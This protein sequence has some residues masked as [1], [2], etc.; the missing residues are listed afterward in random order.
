M[1]RK[2][3]RKIISL[4]IILGV[5]LVPLSFL[6]SAK[7]AKAQLDITN[8]GISG[9]SSNSGGSSL[10]AYIS[11]LGPAITQLPLCKK[12][13]KSGLSD[14]FGSN[15]PEYDD[16]GGYTD[17]S[18][19]IYYDSQG[20]YYGD[21]GVYYSQA[22]QDEETNLDDTST[23]ASAVSESVPVKDGD[24]IK[25]QKDLNKK[26]ADIKSTSASIEKNDTCLKSIGRLIIKMLLQKITMATVN[27]INSGFN[28]GPAFV[29]NP[30]KFFGDIATNEILQFKIEIGDPSKFPF[31][32]A[33]MQGVAKNFSK[34]FADNAQYSLDTMIKATNPK[35]SAIGFSTD[36]TKGGW[37]AWKAMT[38][39]PGNNPMG[40]K[41]EASNE[42]NNRLAGLNKTIA[43]KT[44]EALQ[45]ANGFL[46][47]YRCA[48][49]KG[50]SKEDND[51]GVKERTTDPTG[52]GTYQYDVCKKWEYV[53]PGKIISEKATTAINYPDNQLLKA[54]D[55]NDSLAAIIDALVNHF[56]QKIIDEGL[57]GLNAFSEAG[58]NFQMDYANIDNGS[59]VKTGSTFNSSQIGSSAFLQQNPNFD[60]TKDIT[61]ALIDT[62]R[63]YIDKLKAQNDG[64]MRASSSSINGYD[65]LIPAIYQL[66]YCIP[67]P[68]PDWE[69]KAKNSLAKFEK[70]ALANANKAKTHDDYIAMIGQMAAGPFGGIVGL[71]QDGIDK[72]GSPGLSAQA[73]ELNS[74]YNTLTGANLQINADPKAC[75]TPE[76]FISNINS[77]LSKY[78]GLVKKNFEDL[79]RT[80]S[81]TNE[82]RTQFSKINGY[83]QMIEDNKVKI[84]YI[85]S[86]VTQLENI[87]S[88]VAE[89]ESGFQNGTLELTD[90]NQNEEDQHKFEL[91]QEIDA[92]ANISS[93]IVTGDDIAVADN[94]SKQIADKEDYVK[95][96]TVVDSK[97]LSCENQLSTWALKNSITVANDTNSV[98][99]RPNYQDLHLYDYAGAINTG[100]EAGTGFLSGDTN[101]G[102]HG[103]NAGAFE[104][105][106][107]IY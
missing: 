86:I 40:F 69:N 104:N 71:V 48:D 11:G 93:N 53:T 37:D 61:Q 6:F 26:T 62:Q 32:K 95:S 57:A 107:G 52:T 60:I 99:K 4:F 73:R 70:A 75:T 35:N 101:L 106:L 20:G 47:D 79:S 1:K 13:I 16:S 100:Q 33:F 66:D 92:F 15:T 54:Q 77:T 88:S 82:A 7:T 19:G 94:L 28:G 78:T 96:I 55:L 63:T 64:L 45:E 14:L 97:T 43:Q 105:N 42:L 65:G 58:S 84:A 83:R 90:G 18:T 30:S 3:F 46:G 29:Q 9:G 68:N 12:A 36:F 89:L 31:G 17:E 81:M 2:Y 49:P 39:N 76:Q 102:S 23:T 91:Q 103:E 74:S 5:F 85:Q 98:E 24:S 21:D 59:G 25:Q 8:G 80:L 72:C 38:Q 27:W 34:K 50:L 67:G 56:G 22:A 10:S 41:L 51:K 87:K 44:T